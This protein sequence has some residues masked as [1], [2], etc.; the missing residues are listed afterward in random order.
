MNK[1]IKKAIPV[2]Y[3]QK[4]KGYFRLRST[5]TRKEK[6]N[7]KK[8]QRRNQDGALKGREAYDSPTSTY[9]PTYLSV[10]IHQ[11]VWFECIYSIIRIF[12]K[13]IRDRII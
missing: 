7:H 5:T 6:K 2:K 12:H 10:V 9:L 4:Q 1:K 3:K 11:L 8:T 13:A